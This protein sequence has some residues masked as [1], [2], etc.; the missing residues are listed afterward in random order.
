MTL[1]HLAGLG[2]TLSLVYSGARLEAPAGR[3][4]IYQRYEE[5]KN[6]DHRRDHELKYSSL[7]I[8]DDQGRS[9]QVYYERDVRAHAF[10]EFAAPE[11]VMGDEIKAARGLRALASRGMQ[12]YENVYPEHMGEKKLVKVPLEKAWSVLHRGERGSSPVYVT[13]PHCDKP[14][15]LD[16]GGLKECHPRLLDALKILCPTARMAEE[17]WVES[18]GLLPGC[19][20]TGSLGHLDDLHTQVRARGNPA[21]AWLANPSLGTAGWA[22]QVVRKGLLENP[23]WTGALDQLKH[24]VVELG[25]YAASESLKS[26]PAKLDECAGDPEAL[27]AFFTL[28]AAGGSSGQGLA[29]YRE[30]KETPEKLKMVLDLLPGLEP[31]EVEGKTRATRALSMAEYIGNTRLPGENSVGAFS[32]WQQISALFPGAGNENLLEL[33]SEVTGELRDGKWDSLN[34]VLETLGS[35]LLFTRDPRELRKRL[36]SSVDGSAVSSVPSCIEQW[37]NDL[38]IDGFRLRVQS[39]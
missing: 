5:D 22:Y 33:Y 27:Q 3:F 34:Q 28:A 1:D 29:L 4:G 24:Y 17:I 19:D 10:F 35:H 39:P 36:K 18:E 8:T 15:E 14:Q 38:V 12:L 32:R 37:D 13:S 7:E 9:S 11:A 30:L 20:M 31:R 21:M 2:Y 6:L 26:L 16:L 23:R 25:P